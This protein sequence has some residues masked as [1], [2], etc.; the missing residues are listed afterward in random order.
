MYTDPGVGFLKFE[1]IFRWKHHPHYGVT[2]MNQ[3]EIPQP[4][5][6]VG[7]GLQSILMEVLRGHVQCSQMKERPWVQKRHGSLRMEKKNHIVLQSSQNSLI[8]NPFGDA[9]TSAKNTPKKAVLFSYRNP[10][11]D[12]KNKSQIFPKIYL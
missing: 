2:I 8:P 4:V 1:P 3:E 12:F 6:S 5:A 7:D 11:C 9:D 10:Y